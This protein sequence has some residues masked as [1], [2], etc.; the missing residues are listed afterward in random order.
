MKKKVINR[1]KR[2]KTLTK[3]KPVGSINKNPE[4]FLERSTV[5]KEVPPSHKLLDHAYR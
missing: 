3:V 2:S 4:S 1:G 5:Q